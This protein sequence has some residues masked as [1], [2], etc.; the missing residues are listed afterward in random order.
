[1]LR[2]K[3]T[4]SRRTASALDRRPV[5]PVP[6]CAF[7]LCSRM[8]FGGGAL[9]RTSDT[10][11]FGHICQPHPRC[12]QMTPVL[13]RVAALRYSV[14]LW[15]CI[16]PLVQA[17]SLVL[18]KGTHRFEPPH[19]YAFVDQMVLTGNI[20]SARNCWLFRAEFCVSDYSW[21]AHNCQSPAMI[22]Y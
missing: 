19:M 3:P 5:S 21:P 16:A 20:F 13:C 7:K 15:V 17:V 12:V 10:D 1:M 11:A 4:V 9:T 2:T 14:A 22:Q 18:I 8:S 6:I